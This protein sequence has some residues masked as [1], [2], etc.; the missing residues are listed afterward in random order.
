MFESVSLRTVVKPKWGGWNRQ[1]SS[2][3]LLY[4]S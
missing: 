3:P 4:I 2:F 1:I